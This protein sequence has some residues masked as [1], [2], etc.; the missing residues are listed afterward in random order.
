VSFKVANLVRSRRFG[1]GARKAIALK[2]ADVA[3]DDGSSIYPSIATIA[4]DTEFCQRLVKRTLANFRSEGL[5]Q[6]AAGGGGRTNATRYLM[7][8]AAVS[9]LPHSRKTDLPTPASEMIAT[10]LKVINGAPHAPFTGETVHHMHLNGAP[11]APNPSGTVNSTPSEREPRTE[12][13]SLAS[14]APNGAGAEAPSVGKQIWEEAISLLS[15]FLPEAR[16][17]TLIGKWFKRAKTLESQHKLLAAVRAA[18]RAGTRD[19]VPYLEAAINEA[20]PPPPDAATLSNEEWAFRV[21]VALNRKEWLPEWG[22]KPGERKCLLP[23]SM[24]TPVL[25]S[26]VASSNSRKA[27]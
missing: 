20:L 1:S 8:L 6:V 23:A 16:Y 5:L 17:R 25:I 24:A 27:A 9:T 11:H 18:Q 12:K 19:P 2:L 7:D 13:P 10:N 22:P 15:P 4:R 14:S 26:A 3:N 21:Q